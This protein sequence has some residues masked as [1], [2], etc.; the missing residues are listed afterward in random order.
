[1]KRISLAFVGLLILSSVALGQSNSDNLAKLTKT[2]D[3][4]IEKEKPGWIHHSI[5]P[6]EGSRN[7]IIEQWQSGDV[8]IKVA[9]VEYGV[10]GDAVVA[11]KEF[12]TQLKIE[13]NASAVNRKTAVRLIKEDLPELGD[14]GFAW[15][16]R[17]SEAAAFRKGSYLVFVSIAQ[18]L[19]R[20]DVSLSREFARYVADVIPAL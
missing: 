20:T 2:L 13:E 4:K 14:E 17:G 6:I 18:P 1:M 16:I 11:L 19:Y 15:D 9:V 5:T 12:K 7:I 8:T 10:P 3:E